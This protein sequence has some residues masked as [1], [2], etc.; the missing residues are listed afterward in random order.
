MSAPAIVIYTKTIC[1][2]CVMA[3][4]LL[5]K[6]GLAYTTKDAED[7]KIFEEMMEKSEGRRT[8]PQIF[9][10]GQGIGGFDDLRALNQSGELDKL[11]KS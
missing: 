3:K 9:I 4:A 1:P 5:D 10:N 8:V 2:Y 11:L 7:P 6:K